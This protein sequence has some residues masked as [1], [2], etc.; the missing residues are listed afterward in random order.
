[1]RI[2][3]YGLNFTPELTGI[4]KY[5]GELAE[6]LVKQRHC[7]RVVT[8]PPYYPQWRIS[9]R[10]SSYYY[11][12]EKYNDIDVYRCPLWV[13]RVQ[14]G[15]NRILHLISFAISS[16]PVALYNV[17]WKPD[18]VLTIAPALF[19]APV[20]LLTARI[21]GAKSWLH[22]QD[23]EIDAALGLGM[24]SAGT[25]LHKFIQ[26]LETWL[27]CRFDRVSTISP[28]MM[29]RLWEKGVSKRKSY[30]FPNWIDAQSIYP[31]SKPGAYRK[32]LGFVNS[33][34]V[35][36]YAGNMGAKHGLDVLI[37]AARCLQEVAH[38]KL[39]LCGDGT[40]R[41]D[42]QERAKGMSN[43]HFMPLQPRERLNELLN[44]ADIHVLPQRA[45]AA[46]LVM[47]SKL[48]GMMASGKSVVATAA[49]GTQVAK[50]VNGAGLVVPP[51]DPAALAKAIKQLAGDPG[52]REK[53]GAK[54]RAYAVQHWGKEKVL[55]D[56]QAQLDHLI[57]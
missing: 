52:L 40:A 36:Q 21:A 50:A 17:T 24:L 41:E 29:E 20:G 7:I 11:H 35:V 19:S 55:A 48:T 6:Y 51:E 28:R 43:V 9:Q 15:L 45:D 57:V 49:P 39:V 3:I 13:P 53:L 46:D 44:F 22:I 1:M 4:G 18:V 2:L 33:E 26:A 30:L 14:T 25:F 27:Y 31:L 8:S 5:T 32:E 34:V 47:P 37:E 42:L 38:I 54:G 23:F 16:I 56:F 12:H 10:Y